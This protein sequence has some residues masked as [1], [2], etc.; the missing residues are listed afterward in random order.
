MNCKDYNQK[1]EHCRDCAFFNNDERR[2]RVHCFKHVKKG[3]IRMEIRPVLCT[4]C[5]SFKTCDRRKCKHSFEG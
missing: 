5:N 1:E 4:F 2:V 3:Q